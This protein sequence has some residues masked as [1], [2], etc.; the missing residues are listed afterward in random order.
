[1]GSI[2]ILILANRRERGSCYCW[3][4]E[5]LGRFFFC[6]GWFWGWVLFYAKYC[7]KDR[8]RNVSNVV[9]IEMEGRISGRQMG[10]YKGTRRNGWNELRL[11]F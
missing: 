2:L 8:E 5:K 1:M 3:T 9:A 11:I 4:C 10:K 6:L 7:D